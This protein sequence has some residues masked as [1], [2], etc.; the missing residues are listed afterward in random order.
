MFCASLF[1]SSSTRACAGDAPATSAMEADS[2]SVGVT[3][4]TLPSL[5][6]RPRTALTRENALHTTATA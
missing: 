5:P 6:R 3:A 4:R 2:E 1:F